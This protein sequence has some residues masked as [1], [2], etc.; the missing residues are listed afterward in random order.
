[1][2]GFNGILTR[3]LVA[4]QRF[5]Y[6]QA[7]KLSTIS[8]GFAQTISAIYG[9]SLSKIII[10]PNWAESDI[11]SRDSQIG[12]N[13]T[14]FGLPEGFIVTYGGNVGTAQGL[15]ALVD[16]A[17]CLKDIYNLTIVIAGEGVE[18]LRL[19]KH[20]KDINSCNVV[21]LPKLPPCTMGALLSI[22]D[23]LYLGLSK[24][25]KYE[26]TIPSKTYAYLSSGKPILAAVAGDTA[27]LVTKY[28]V[29]LVIPPEDVAAIASAIKGAVLGNQ[30]A[31]K[32]MGDQAYHISKTEYSGPL[33]A[34]CYENAFLSFK[35]I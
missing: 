20:A 9:I 27:E 6:I 24:E 15:I 34:K 17:A 4:S 1:L 19:V 10:L 14:E 28:G 3:L 2:H 25:T 12:H 32:K 11:Y 21:F 30:S 22:S 16:A 8:S 23:L 29:G 35:H 26:M 7:R 5:I 31:L 13:R 18:K 33:I